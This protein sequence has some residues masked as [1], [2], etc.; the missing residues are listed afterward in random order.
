MFF[1][2]PPPDTSN[3]MVAGY[4]V[5]FV[6]MAIYLASLLIRWRNLTQDMDALDQLQRQ[7][8]PGPRLKTRPS[9]K[10]RVARR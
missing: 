1:Q 4:I 2:E 5:A 3:Y 10:R 8:P 6:V 9:R 7:P